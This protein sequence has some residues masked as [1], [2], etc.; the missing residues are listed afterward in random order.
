MLRPPKDAMAIETQE[1]QVI[2]YLL[3]EV[4]EAEV[5]I[6]FPFPHS[7]TLSQGHPHANDNEGCGGGPVL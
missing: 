7:P 5:G 4:R 3:A 1:D 6:M 2:S